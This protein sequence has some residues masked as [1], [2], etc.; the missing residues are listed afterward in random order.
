MTDPQT[1][2]N[3]EIVAEI[4]QL[5]EQHGLKIAAAES[6]TSGAVQ[7]A[8]GSGKGAS[9]WFRGGVTA[10]Q[11]DVKFDVLDVEEG[12]V[13][14]PSCALQMARG[15]CK[16]VGADASVATTGAGGPDAQDGQ[17]PG[18]VFIAVRVGDTEKAEGFFFDAEPADVVARSITSALQLLLDA[19]RAET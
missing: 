6:L 15:V 10:Y 2:E 18:T 7:S 11:D 12:P 1:G 14:T 9:S 13:V 4:A 3:Q 8:L 19:L 17:P 16:L 5:A